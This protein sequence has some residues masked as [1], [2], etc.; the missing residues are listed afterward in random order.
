MIDDTTV[1]AGETSKQASID[2]ITTDGRLV[3]LVCV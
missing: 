1:E 3:R 2:P